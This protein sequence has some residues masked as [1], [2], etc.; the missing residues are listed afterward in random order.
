M[1]CPC[2][3]A[4]C[5]AA[6]LPADSLGR[7][8]GLQR[9][10]GLEGHSLQTP[11]LKPDL[12]QRTEWWHPGPA[13]LPHCSVGLTW[14][15]LVIINTHFL[16]S[17]QKSILVNRYLGLVSL[18]ESWACF[19]L[20]LIQ[21]KGSLSP[22]TVPHWTYLCPSSF[23]LWSLPRSFTFSPLPNKNWTLSS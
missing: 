5:P 18:P 10:L 15:S 1:L 21:A 19:C 14:A 22:F 16:L 12:L 20:W 23:V 7:T 3:S 2:W 4:G 13:C 11:F 17:R 6:L 9:G 8:W